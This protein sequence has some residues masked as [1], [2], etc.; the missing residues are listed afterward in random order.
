MISLQIIMSLASFHLNLPTYH[1]ILSLVSRFQKPAL[2]AGL[3]R[4]LLFPVQLSPL[5]WAQRP[6]KLHPEPSYMVE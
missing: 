6:V 3:K 2:L 1:L 5:R 4:L